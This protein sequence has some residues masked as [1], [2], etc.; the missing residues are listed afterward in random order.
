MKKFYLWIISIIILSLN[1]FG[2]DITE[3]DINYWIGSG[4]NKGIVILYFCIEEPS[5]A[6]AFGYKWNFEEI[7]YVNQMLDDITANDSRIILG[8]SGSLM[9]DYSYVDENEGI[10]LNGG[11]TGSWMYDVN[12]S[13]ASWGIESQ[14]IYDGDIFTFYCAECMENWSGIDLSGVNI[15]PVNAPVSA[16]Q[17]TITASAVVGGAISPVGVQTVTE[18][19]N[20]RFTF[21]PNTNYEF[22]SLLIDNAQVN[23]SATSYTFYNVTDN[24]TIYVEFQEV[25]N[26]G[27]TEDD[28]LYWAGSGENTS[29][30]AVS[31][32]DDESTTV[33]VWGYRYD[34]QVNSNIQVDMVI[35]IASEDPRLFYV[36]DQPGTI[37]GIGYDFN[38][39]GNFALV[40]PNDPQDIVYPDENGAFSGSIVDM[41]YVPLDE[42]DLWLDGWIAGFWFLGST[43]QDW[44]SCSFMN[45]SSYSTCSLDEEYMIAAEPPALTQHII[46]ASSSEGG[47]ISPSGVQ[48]VAEGENIQFTFTPDLNYEFAGLL[49]DGVPVNDSVTSYTF[50]S[51]TENHTI[52]VTFNQTT[53]PQYTITASAGEGGTIDPSGV[54][55]IDEGGS[56]RFAFS[57]NQHYLLESLMVDGSAVTDSLSSYTFLNVREN[58]TINV[59]FTFAYELFDGAVGT[60]GCLGVQNIDE[61]IVSWATECRLTRGYK[62]IAN[63]A[64]GLAQFGTVDEALGFASN[65]N[66]DAVSLGH[67]GIA[68]LEF[69]RPIINGDGIDFAV[70]ENSF[71]DSYLELAFVEVSSDG[72]NFVRFP[73]T[74]YTQT[75]VQ[76]GEEGVD[77][78]YINNLA[79]KYTIGWGTPFDLEELRDVADLDINNVK[80]VKLIDVVGTIDPEYA[81]FDSHGNIINCNYTTGSAAGFDLMGIAVIN[82][83]EPYIINVV[84][85]SELVKSNVSLY[86][87]PC[88]SYITIENAYEGNISIYT[89]NG[90]EV[91]NEK[92]ASDNMT[93]NVETLPVGTYFLTVRTKSNVQ[94]IKFE[95]I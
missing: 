6:Y 70:F 61:R 93:I 94:T 4:S 13:L 66:T 36:Q 62:D 57:P 16:T 28:I 48:T 30:L 35:N 69:D 85:D 19:D 29:V 49:I 25:P 22:A 41:G 54:R 73:S 15:I 92:A 9:T 21:S 71:N 77:P 76:A 45:F 86:P 72:E 8:N 50:F 79:G 63:P 90:Q 12:G 87:N 7:T 58:H 53:A 23:D 52:S 84:D 17:Y 46:T 68:I 55:I 89:L 3:N 95:K 11:G 51:I 59:S 14:E 91:F 39:S 38:N 2:Q 34:E 20:L 37:Q 81:T 43:Y 32:C 74:S 75:T 56:I 40:N 64:D 27:F 18:G 83:G 5:T 1:V 65:V 67:G 10:S 42:E 24:H 26:Q 82:G 88:I 60:E 44:P 47:T 80:Y 78:R 33:L 31:W